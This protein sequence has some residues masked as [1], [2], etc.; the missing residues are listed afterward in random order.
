MDVNKILKK[1]MNMYR[2]RIYFKFK[3]ELEF[4]FEN[5]N[6]DLE[7]DL[8]CNV[9]IKE[10]PSFSYLDCGV[11]KTKE[12]AFITGYRLKKA[13]LYYTFRHKQNIVFAKGN[14]K[15]N[16]EAFLKNLSKQKREKIDLQNVEDINVYDEN[17]EPTFI[18]ASAK[19][20]FSFNKD[21]EAFI[22]NIKAGNNLIY[23]L[24]DDLTSPLDLFNDYLVVK[25]IK[26]KFIILVKI[27]DTMAMNICKLN[28]DWFGNCNKIAKT[29]RNFI[30]FIRL[31]KNEYYG[32]NSINFY[33]EL[34]SIRSAIVHHNKI[35]S[36]QFKD[37]DL[38]KFLSESEKLIQDCIEGYFSHFN[39][40]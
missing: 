15:F 18:T 33:N 26:F 39:N 11:C 19:V 20:T 4:K 22:S 5:S 38:K 12:I 3:E 16:R 17:K 2:V 23:N 34:Q 27:L 8:K 1:G 25:D 7:K 10:H 14:F 36:N 29:V 31:D 13:L 24:K 40:K 28:K 9:V 37:N 32:L 35:E 6:F 21:E 30:K